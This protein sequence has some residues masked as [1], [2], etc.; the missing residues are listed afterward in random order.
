MNSDDYEVRTKILP[1]ELVD[2]WERRCIKYFKP[3]DN[4][5][6]YGG[7]NDI[8]VPKYLPGDF[9]YERIEENCVF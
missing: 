5:M 3:C 4:A 6:L 9:N 1:V 2:Y 8:P 7:E